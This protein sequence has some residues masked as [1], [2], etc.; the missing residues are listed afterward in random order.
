MN[1]R[2]TYMKIKKLSYK[3]LI[4]ALNATYMLYWS[5]LSNVF[6]DGSVVLDKNL[7]KIL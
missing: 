1:K 3:Y 7:C 2:N 5:D 4:I 6:E